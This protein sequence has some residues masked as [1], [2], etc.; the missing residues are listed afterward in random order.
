MNST[1]K[2]VICAC[3]AFGLVSCSSY[4]RITVAGTP[5]TDI[6]TPGYDKLGTIQPDGQVEVK[7]S[8]KT[9]YSYLLY[10]DVKTGMNLPFAL[11][12]RNVNQRVARVTGA[13]FCFTGLGFFI[14][15]MIILSPSFKQGEQYDNFKYLSHQI[16]N[17]NLS[18]TP[19]DNNGFKRSPVGNISAA[20]ADASVGNVDTSSSS[21]ISSAVRAR[22]LKRR[23][24][25]QDYG[26]LLE[27]TY[28]GVGSLSY[29][30]EVLERYNNM[31]VRLKRLDDKHVQVEVYE[32]NGET[33]F[34][35]G[36]R[37]AIE[38]TG[39]D[40]FFLSLEGTPS[41]TISVSQDHRLTYH[42]SQVDIG[43][44]LYTLDIS[45]SK[46]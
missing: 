3:V 11:D 22:L 44:D 30:T 19:Y 29:G 31:K 23:A 27:G 35:V 34:N 4:Q 1:V 20:S 7:V 16:T 17:Q 40:E 25:L 24:A 36:H 37:Y 9:Y 45:A 2:S 21:S 18:F 10:R 41:A 38:K 8:K 14:P 13:F 43:G 6:Y 33:F 39:E 26:K 15:G 46:E 32:S 12:Y 28:V 42:H 5:G